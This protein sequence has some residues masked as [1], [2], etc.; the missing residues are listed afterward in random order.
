MKGKVF[1]VPPLRTGVILRSFYYNMEGGREGRASGLTRTGN[2]RLRRRWRMVIK[3]LISRGIYGA[4][5]RD[6]TSDLLITNQRLK[7][8]KSQIINCFYRA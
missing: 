8:F 3:P 4:S 1:D 5:E 7:R 6:R 2:P